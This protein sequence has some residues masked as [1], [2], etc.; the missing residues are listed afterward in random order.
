MR[1]RSILLAVLLI[2]VLQTLH[3][4][5]ASGRLLPHLAVIDRIC[6]EFAATNHV[7]GM[8]VGIVADGRL[9][10]TVSIGYVDRDRQRPVTPSSVFRIASMSK[11]F[12][13]MAILRLRE[14]G[15]L[16]L[17]DPVSTYIPAMSSLAYPTRDAEPVTIRHLLTHGAG[18]PEDNPWG[19]RQLS[20]SDEELVALLRKGISFS[21]APGTAYE[22]SNLGFALLGRIVTLA[23]GMPYQTYIR[24]SIWKPLG[25][26]ASFWEYADVPSDRLAHGYRWQ[27]GRWTEEELLHDRSD[28]SWGA[29]GGM[30]SSVEDMAAYM[31]LH[32]SAWPPS[33]LTETGPVRRSAIREMQHPWRLSGLN[34]AYAYPGGRACPVVTAYGYGLRWTR[35]C[36]GRV[37]VGH[38]GGLPGFGTHWQ[39]MPD[40]GIGIVSLANRT[41]APMSALNMQLLDTLIR[42]SGI[43]PRPVPVSAILE[44]RQRELTSYIVDWKGAEASGIFA[45]NFFPDY[46]LDLL[47]RESREVFS[48]VGRI[49]R[50]GPMVAE[51]ALRGTYTLDCERGRVEVSFTMSPEN[52]PLIQAYRIR[53]LE[54]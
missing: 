34:T 17:D 10:H 9:V 25:M 36:E 14:G 31:R 53:I 7:P 1:Y 5:S 42:L 48:K 26:G 27:D 2:P 16:R 54:P 3:A 6:A 4:Q 43:G 8:A 13:A 23:S 24:D 22:Y 39:V 40:Y 12:T 47:Q 15:R 41:Y 33:D 35:D 49:L 28:G 21:T 18:F 11:S 29:M 20:D 38:S 37:Y 44:Q 45:E 52:P 32:L 19:D 46:R 51:N 30:L 50:Q